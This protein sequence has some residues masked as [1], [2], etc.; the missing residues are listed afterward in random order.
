MEKPADSIIRSRIEQIV[1]SYNRDTSNSQ[2]DY[3]NCR[4]YEHVSW[5]DGVRLE[6]AE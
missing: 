6:D 2:V 5:A 3:F 1:G 4:F